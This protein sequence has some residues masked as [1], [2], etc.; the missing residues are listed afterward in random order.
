MTASERKQTML[1]HI[2]IAG[3]V[4][5]PYYDIINPVA[6]Q[7][8]NEKSRLG[9]RISQSFDQYDIS[10]DISYDKYLQIS[11]DIFIPHFHYTQQN[12]RKY[13]G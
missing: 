3:V 10:Y 7:P 11:S 9:S 4:L 2:Q 5:L 13:V 6:N 12:P 8:Q 1:P